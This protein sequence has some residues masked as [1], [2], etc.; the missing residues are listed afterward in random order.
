[1][2]ACRECPRKL[3]ELTMA[4]DPILRAADHDE[5][6]RSRTR[7]R[8]RVKD[9]QQLLTPAL[10]RQRSFCRRTHAAAQSASAVRVTSCGMETISVEVQ[11]GS[12]TIWW[13]VT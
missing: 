7:H 3:R 11:N 10:K 8:N 1:M 4:A 5:H 6:A 9:S 12:P 13:Y 2:S